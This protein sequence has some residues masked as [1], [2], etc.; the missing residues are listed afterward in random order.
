MIDHM[1]AG[2]DR[3]TVLGTVLPAS[4]SPGLFDLQWSTDDSWE[5]PW[6]LLTL[7]SL[8]KVKTGL[9]VDADD[10]FQEMR[11]W[12]APN[13]LLPLRSTATTVLKQGRLPETVERMHVMWACIPEEHAVNWGVGTVLDA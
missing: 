7:R 4:F 10:L 5:T 9:A 2:Y 3:Q 8:A 11:P 12:T 6:S 13:V 1:A